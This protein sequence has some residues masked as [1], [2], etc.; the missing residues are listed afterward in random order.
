MEK[1]MNKQKI[2]RPSEFYWG[3]YSICALISLNGYF[4]THR[5]FFF[6]CG[7]AFFVMSILTRIK[8]IKQ[9]LDYEQNGR[10]KE[11]R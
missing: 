7:L 8:K 5:F 2:L 1:E 10:T 9:G 11:R 6:I 3:V 4:I